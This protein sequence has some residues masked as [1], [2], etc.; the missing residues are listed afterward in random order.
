MTT[1]IISSSKPLLEEIESLKQ[2]YPELSSSIDNLI[3][4][5]KSI[6]DIFNNLLI[7][8]PDSELNTSVD[9]LNRSL[10]MLQK[11]MI[12]DN[13]SKLLLIIE[14]L[15]KD[16]NLYL[17]ELLKLI[18]TLNEKIN[19]LSIVMATKNIPPP[20]PAEIAQ[21]ETAVKGYI[22]NNIGENLVS[23]L[24]TMQ[25]KT[26]LEPKPTPV[27]KPIPVELKPIPAPVPKPVEPKPVPTPAPKPVEPKPEPAPKPVEPIIPSKLTGNPVDV[28]V[29]LRIMPDKPNT[30]IK[31]YNNE[32]TLTTNNTDN[33]QT[34][35]TDYFSG[36]IPQQYFPGSIIKKNLDEE[37]YNNILPVF[38]QLGTGKNILISN[39]GFSGSGKTYTLDY[40]L[41]TFYANYKAKY[42]IQLYV[43]EQY[44]HLSVNPN[45]NPTTI[46]TKPVF[47]EYVYYYTLGTNGLEHMQLKFDKKQDFPTNLFTATQN[48]SDIKNAI[49]NYRKAIKFIKPTL[50]AKDSG[51]SHLYYKFVCQNKSTGISGILTAIDF[52]GQ[53]NSQ[54]VL[55]S[56]MD[57]N[58]AIFN[59]YFKYL[60]GNKVSVYVG[61]MN[62]DIA[63][64]STEYTK[65]TVWKIF[66]DAIK[67]FVGRP[68]GLTDTKLKL[69]D[70]NALTLLKQYDQGKLPLYTIWFIFSFL[71]PIELFLLIKISSD[72]GAKDSLNRMVDKNKTLLNLNTNITT[73]KQSPFDLYKIIVTTL[74]SSISEPDR[75][76]VI[77]N[78]YAIYDNMVKFNG[79]LQKM[80]GQ[81]II[82]NPEVIDDLVQSFLEGFYINES[83]A[84]KNNYFKTIQNIQI[85]KP[86]YNPVYDKSYSPYAIYGVTNDITAKMLNMFNT[87]I[88]K[89]IEVVTIRADEYAGIR[90]NENTAIKYKYARAA[91]STLKAAAQLAN[92]YNASQLLELC[93]PP[94]QKGGNMYY[95]YMKYKHKYLSLLQY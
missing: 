57:D 48:L 88:E 82:D 79:V 50:N 62:K 28:F 49:S 22:T 20:E 89:I 63:M 56:Y 13:S 61:N 80:Y 44:G 59:T 84:S 60:Y 36:V 40:I 31:I 69:L 55:L 70:D 90:P 11:K 16:K 71:Y 26:T 2:K 64:M 72:S 10:F 58:I 38:D 23:K 53:E 33:K 8:Y 95:K 68:H 25:Q 43:Y 7:S 30:H 27:P 75:N 24:V 41:D 67:L 3:K 12:D 32:I 39:S 19:E 51:R 42:N 15:R 35:K 21:V 73:K 78:L 52:A 94:K 18:K 87:N 86:V 83:N 74:F 81:T 93:M 77:N 1:N 34:I 45:A 91:C 47:D 14:Q 17:G 6:G 92:K 85:T 9:K 65:N 29:K 4:A 54:D 46:F 37:L 66:D 76:F 5:D